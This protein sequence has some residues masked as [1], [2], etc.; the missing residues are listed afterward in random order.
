[1]KKV[2]IMSMQRVINYGSFLQAYALKSMIEELGCSVCFVDYKVEPCL[3]SGEN[4]PSGNVTDPGFA[5]KVVRKLRYIYRLARHLDMRYDPVKV[6]SMNEKF[7][8][9]KKNYSSQ[10]INM[11]G[12]NDDRSER[13]KVDT[14]VI[15]SDEVFNCLQTNKDIG[16]SKELFGFDN[17]ASKV[18]SYAASF[19]NTTLEG[20][21][22]YS[23]QDEIS[24][25]LKDFS[26]VS[27]R[28][29]NSSCIVKKLTGKDPVY[30]LD[31]V[32]MYDFS[33]LIPE[34]PEMSQYIVVYAYKGRISVSEA[35]KIREFAARRKMKLVCI[36][37]PQ[38]FC[39]EYINCD[40]FQTLAY[41]NHAQYV[42]TDTFHGSIFS[43]INNKKFG[44]IVRRSQNGSYGNEEKITDLLKRLGLSSQ[45]IY[46][47][48]SLDS[49]LSENIDYA[50][51]NNYI[52]QERKKTREY[53]KSNI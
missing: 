1:M 7:E 33:P 3:V 46:D 8:T 13:T 48:N 17:N 37:G 14:L 25:F 39:D 12:I 51:V 23:I 19:G 35:Q 4:K 41:F 44:V 31:P 49:I 15:G 27:V 22:K 52:S 47:M 50:R 9:F 36:G 18:I 20:L 40:P 24:S 45:I 29:E 10:Y 30:N 6:S 11:L 28:D 43:V 5:G 16:Y 53:L 2:G 32:L 42:I 38:Y 26:S 21:K 34:I